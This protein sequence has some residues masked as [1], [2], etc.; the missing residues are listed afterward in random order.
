MSPP[1]PVVLVP[2]DPEWPNLAAA[3]A[4]RLRV[5]GSVLVTVHHIG[6]TS[7]PGLA[8]KPVIDLMPLVTD[9]S[10]LDRERSRL[11]ALGYEWYGEFGIAGRRHC[12]LSDEIGN[13]AVNIHFFKVDSP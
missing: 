6:S 13:R 9:L 4:G 10:A 2:Y 3:Q 1:I 7:V 8:A 5:L 11:E 12:T